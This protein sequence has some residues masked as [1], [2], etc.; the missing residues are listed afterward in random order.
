MIKERGTVQQQEMEEARTQGTPLCAKCGWYQGLSHKCWLKADRA[1]ER[2]RAK[3]AL[4]STR[5]GYGQH[6]L[7]FIL[8]PKRC[9]ITFAFDEDGTIRLANFFCLMH[10]FPAE[11]ALLVNTIAKVF[12]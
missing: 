4:P 9:T 8:V 1:A 3:V 6:R 2:L 5:L 10:F 7:T 11:A 12:P